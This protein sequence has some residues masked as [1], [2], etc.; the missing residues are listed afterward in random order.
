MWNRNVDVLLAWAK[1]ELAAGM[2]TKVVIM[3]ATLDASAL[4]EFFGGAPIIN[5]PGR[6]FPVTEELQRGTV[7]DEALR[8]SGMGRNVLV[9]L[10]GKGEIMQFK[11]DMEERGTA[12]IVIP[13]HGELTPEEQDRAFRS[14]D[15]P[16]VVAAT[17]VAQTSITIPDIDAVVDSGVDIRHP[18]LKQNIAR[19]GLGNDIY[20]DVL[21]DASSS[22]DAC[23]GYNFDWAT[24]YKD[25]THPGPDGHGHGTHVAGI[26]A[27]AGG[28]AD[29][30]AEN[31]VGVAPA[32]TI[33]PVKTMDC[34][35]EGQDWDIAYGIK[36][37]ADRGAKIM[38]LSIG[39]PE[40]SAL[41]EDA[42]AYA[43]A[44]GVLIVVAAGNGGGAPVFYPAAYSG[45]IAVGAVSRDDL[46]QSFSNVGLQM[47]MVAPGGTINQ[48]VE[49]ILSTVPTYTS[50]MSRVGAGWARVSGTS[51]ASP[52]V[53]G[54]AA[55]IWSREPALSAEQVRERLF[56][57][58]KDLGTK[59][60][61]TKYGWGRLDVQAALAL[62]DHRYAAP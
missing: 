60:F 43:M 13:L 6:L 61:D 59:G 21:H 51:Q 31:L 22:F 12:A 7:V 46:Y 48:S 3:S 39:G 36:A 9:F 16:K 45:V 25:A 17:N 37:A 40:P 32:A 15:R 29:Y 1:K 20:I 23:R 50:E 56:A 2:K 28:N 5:V 62:G 52:F 38:N 42:L 41:L 44:R 35:G 14:Y 18:D 11:K 58:A 57:S 4:A 24:A 33:L 54:A 19:D 27:A 55:L 34:N 8:L 47:G 49:G 26:V 53:A 30:G 10:P